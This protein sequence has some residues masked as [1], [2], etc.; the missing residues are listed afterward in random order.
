MLKAW[1]YRKTL[2]SK[3]GRGGGKR[4]RSF[5][6]VLFPTTH[7]HHLREQPREATACPYFLN[8][9]QGEGGDDRE[10]PGVGKKN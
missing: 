8:M 10:G 6:L 3:D 7:P 2:K 9:I 5:A 1:Y 4:K